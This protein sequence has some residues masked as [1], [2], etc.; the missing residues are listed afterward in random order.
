VYARVLF[1]LAAQMSGPGGSAQVERRLSISLPQG[2]RRFSSGTHAEH[3]EVDVP[4][5]GRDGLDHGLCRVL[6]RRQ[7]ASIQ[8]HQG[9]GPEEV[10]PGEP[11]RPL[12]LT[13][14]A[15]TL[16]G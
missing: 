16:F 4:R 11:I 14:Q 10:K 1:D 6:R 13:H 12:R 9:T 15:E 3:R 7:L 5:Q 8:M 2:Q